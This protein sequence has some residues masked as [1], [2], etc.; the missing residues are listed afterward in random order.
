MR[1]NPYA[2]GVDVELLYVEHCPNVALARERLTEALQQA[3]VDASVREQV[4][5]DE[6]QAVRF[7]MR[8]S[9]TIR[10]AGVDVAAGGTD[11]GALSCRLYRDGDRVQGAP[12]V[13]DLAAALRRRLGTGGVDADRR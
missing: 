8:G 12:S 4:V 3:G 10:I 2:T 6:A 7:G 5:R 1:W 9:P 13:A 11:D